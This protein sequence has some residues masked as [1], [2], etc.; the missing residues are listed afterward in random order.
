MQVVAGAV[1]GSRA[2]FAE[3]EV[4][5][6]LAAQITSEI[7][8][9]LARVAV[10]LLVL[11]RTD[12]A[13]LSALALAL[14][15]IPPILGS[16]LLGPFADRY[17]RRQV[18]LVCDAA[19]AALVV[20]LAVI[21][22]PGVPLWLPIVLLLV[23]EFFTAP[24]EASR[25]ALWADVVPR[26]RDLLAVSGV[27]QVLAQATQVLG[28]VVGGL[29]VTATS[30]RLALFV[31]SATFVVSYLL[32]TAFVV[33]RGSL[34][35]AADVRPFVE[36]LRAGIAAVFTH[37]VRRALIVLAW[38]ITPL[39]VSA[40]AVALPYA[41]SAGVPRLGAFLLAAVPAGA[42]LGAALATRF[43]P[44][45]LVARIQLL[46]AAAAIPLLLTAADPPPALTLVLWVAAGVS[47]GLLVPVLMV[48]VAA[49]TP[50]ALRG[51]VNGVAAGGFS[52]F[53]ALSYVVT[54]GV[55][56]L[57]A[58]HL[59]VG[60]VGALGLAVAAVATRSWPRA[61]VLAAV[62]ATSLDEPQAGTAS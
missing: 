34:V 41:E 3:R 53:I 25:S 26:P 7:G 61:E 48:S 27:S 28:L 43:D 35:A 55:A 33:E 60:L 6:L 30:P 8:D 62:S 15:H 56:D 17:S 49:V 10:A 5:G 51:R 14:S 23:T 44:A 1:S 57:T 39:L 36:D 21:A 52:L 20:V 22:V 47:Q 58:E 59:A 46:I 24:F 42:A 11:E 32:I 9:S 4:R 38:M 2:V 45:R 54:G 31:D 50:P 18:L 16:A 12:S 29:L 37:R 40:E 13:L 19:R